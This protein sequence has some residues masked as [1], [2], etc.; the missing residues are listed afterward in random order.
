MRCWERL[1]TLL[2]TAAHCLIEKQTVFSD[3]VEHPR[4]FWRRIWEGRLRT[5][6]YILPALI[7]AWSKDQNPAS[8]SL[9]WM[10][11][12]QITLTY[13]KTCDWDNRNPLPCHALLF[14]LQVLVPCRNLFPGKKKSLSD[15]PDADASCLIPRELV[16]VVFEHEQGIR[17]E[18]RDQTTP[19]EL[20]SSLTSWKICSLPAKERSLVGYEEC[21]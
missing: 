11:N 9:V 7:S 6:K 21:E 12:W 14:C 17:G 20:L 5:V 18:P 19:A 13:G 10:M 8:D 3:I 2:S 15:R 4:P 16:L 1:D